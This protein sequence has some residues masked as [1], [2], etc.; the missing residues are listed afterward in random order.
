MG[1]AE[2]V[3]P[4]QDSIPI[5]LI[6]RVSSPKDSQ[7]TSLV[8]QKER[9]AAY[10]AAEFSSVATRLVWNERVA[11][12]LNF[13]HPKLVEL[14]QLILNGSLDNGYILSCF[15]DRI[16]RFGHEVVELLCKQHNIEVRYI[17]QLDSRTE[18]EELTEDLL[19]VLT[20]YTAKASG[21][22]TR[23][24]YAVQI[25][26]ATASL[27]FDLRNQK[28][29]LREIADRLKQE[30]KHL[31]RNGRPLSYQVI[32]KFLKRHGGIRRK[33]L[34]MKAGADISPATS[35][36]GDSLNAF[37]AAHVLKNELQPNGKPVFTVF[38]TFYSAYEAF[39]DQHSLIAHS[40]NV[41]P[42]ML[43]SNGFKLVTRRGYLGL[44]A[45]LR[46]PD[47]KLC[48][49]KSRLRKTQPPEIAGNR[50]AFAKYGCATKSFSSTV[51]GQH[52]RKQS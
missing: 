48:I 51:L 13:S 31:D 46:V 41:L 34:R 43:R 50:R 10:V 40:R 9:L 29:S 15:K 24:L 32:F 21:N 20:H 45:A 7:K 3:H 23:K 37:V 52:A 30:G 4:S 14:F 5:C 17:D 44:Y 47:A 6:T 2:E 38:K 25:D 12:G 33:L 22:K 27:I 16:L 36:V 19:S 1:R 39:C 35:P 42:K 28:V 49:E 26:E 11:S 18:N 8:N